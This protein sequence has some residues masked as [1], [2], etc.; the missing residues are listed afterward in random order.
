MTGKGHLRSTTLQKPTYLLIKIDV[1]IQK[2]ITVYHNYKLS[3]WDKNVQNNTKP[4]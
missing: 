4:T 3:R 2:Y 1:N